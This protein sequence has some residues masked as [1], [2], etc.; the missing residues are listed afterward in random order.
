[1]NFPRRR[2]ALTRVLALLLALW[3]GI[4]PTILIAADAPGP[5]NRPLAAQ[6]SSSTADGQRVQHSLAYFLGGRAQVT[7]RY[8]DAHLDVPVPMGYGQKVLEA[9]L[10]LRVIPSAALDS[11]SWMVVL[12]NGQVAGQF[13]LAGSQGPL[14][15][16]LALPGSLFHPGFN[17]IRLRAAQHYAPHCEYP[18]AGQIWS[19]IQLQESSL[20]LTLSPA[21]WEPNLADLAQ[22]FDPA[23]TSDEGRLALFFA[24]SASAR[25]WEATALA[26][27]GAALRYQYLPLEVQAQSFSA[28]RLQAWLQVPA[29]TTKTALF[30][31]SA[32][33]LEPLLQSAQVQARTALPT[34]RILRWPGHPRHL[35]VALI[36]EGKALVDLAKA[37]A[38][39]AVL[40]PPLDEASVRSARFPSA[41]KTLPPESTAEFS[42]N[43]YALSGLGFGTQTRTGYDP[44]PLTLRLWNGGWQRKAQLRLH[45]AYAAGMSPQSALNVIVNGGALGSIPL[46]NP[47]GGRYTDYTVT[48]PPTVLHPGWNDVQLEP[49]L[50]PQSNGG[51][52]RPV[53]LGNLWVTVY[54]DSVFQWMGGGLRSLQPDLAPLAYKAY[55]FNRRQGDKLTL[56]GSSMSDANVSAAMTL[57]GKLSQAAGRALPVRFVAQSDPLPDADIYV[58]NLQGKDAWTKIPGGEEALFQQ[59]P[60]V[61]YERP[62]R[63]LLSLLHE[64][65]PI[66]WA[67]AKILW[68]ADH[69]A[70]LA[71]LRIWH[72]GGR[73]HVLLTASDPQ[74]L[75][76]ATQNLIQYGPWAQL[77][78]SL[79]WWHIGSDRVFTLGMSETPF[80]T[81]GVRGGLALWISRHPWISL[82]VL[83][84]FGFLFVLATRYALR[85]YALRRQHTQALEDQPTATDNLRSL[86]APVTEITEPSDATADTEPGVSAQTIPTP[87]ASTPPGYAQTF[88]FR[89]AQGDWHRDVEDPRRW[90]IHPR[91]GT[92]PR[93]MAP[94]PFWI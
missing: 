83:L 51:D 4:S 42:Q 80:R 71:F 92:P 57:L 87:A 8:T 45:L 19:Q 31:G 93:R 34:L 69:R 79:A 88:R 35:G 6:A 10:K 62:K 86:A 12:V 17:T 27:E 67:R 20:A 66:E 9:K 24:R 16:K 23:Q 18:L 40:W 37:F 25:D 52:C 76:E 28:E 13:S 50:V 74:K 75:R 54:G 2:S 11:Q 59:E 61:A 73:T 41:E 81:F 15:Q 33:T 84:F 21:A 70:D 38:H 82:A 78:G 72:D 36:G 91:H 30:V 7:L 55:P 48:L 90:Y 77:K 58:G 44:E 65:V 1:M 85:Q 68:D 39:P 94:Y 5:M 46:N 14:E 26:V 53:F 60:G 89:V 3:F 29:E 32:K 49:V 63:G 22:I 43:A 64:P 56:Q 47:Q